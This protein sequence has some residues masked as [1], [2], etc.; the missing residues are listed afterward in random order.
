MK[1]NW[2]NCYQKAEKCIS[3]SYITLPKEGT[4]HIALLEFVECVY[5]F[6]CV[7]INTIQQIIIIIIIIII[8]QK[9]KKE[10]EI[11]PQNIILFLIT[12]MNQYNK[13][14]L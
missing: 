4:S 13:L 7:F 8:Q 2:T 14:K 11:N 5:L 1:L 6:E 10:E 3:E 12:R 9:K